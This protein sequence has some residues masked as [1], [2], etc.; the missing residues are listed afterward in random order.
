[1]LNAPKPIWFAN[2]AQT[3]KPAPHDGEVEVFDI[4]QP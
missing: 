4:D 2:P 1:M 3:D